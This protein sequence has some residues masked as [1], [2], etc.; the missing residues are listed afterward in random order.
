[1]FAYLQLQWRFIMKINEEYS[2]NNPRYSKLK[3]PMRKVMASYQNGARWFDTLQEELLMGKGLQQIPKIIHN[4]AHSFPKEF[5]AF[6][7]IL[8]TRNLKVEYP[9]TDEIIFTQEELL[10]DSVFSFI[11]KVIGSIDIELSNIINICDNDTELKGMVDSLSALQQLN[12][13]KM[14]IVLNM[15]RMFDTLTLNISDEHSV[16][17]SFENWIEEHIG[18]MSDED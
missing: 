15:W 16:Y 11:L 4:M 13:Q 12:S 8:H 17:I 9:A 18:D 14:D 2:Y 5:D 7:E 10:L 6:S 3:E 1:M